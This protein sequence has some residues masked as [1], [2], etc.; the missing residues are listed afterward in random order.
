MQCIVLNSIQS[1]VFAQKT[2]QAR[3][4]LV[5]L[6]TSLRKQLTFRDT[7]TLEVIMSK[8]QAQKFHADVSQLGSDSLRL[9]SLAA[10]FLYGI[11]V[12]VS[13]TLFCRQTIGDVTECWLFSQ[14]TLLLV[15]PL[16]S[17]HLLQ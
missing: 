11:F 5:S 9:I 12:I 2:K 7:T 13:Q 17:P 1:M 15:I 10:R 3:G 8:E 6:L 16:L 14:S 4:Y